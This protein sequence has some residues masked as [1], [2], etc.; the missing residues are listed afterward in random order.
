[1]VELGSNI[2]LEI[3]VM[4]AHEGLTLTEVVNRLNALHPNKKPTTVQNISN[5][6]RRGTIKYSEVAEIAKV[7]NIRLFWINGEENEYGKL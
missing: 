3:K 7:A 4:L 5:K 1:M 2:Y 6:L